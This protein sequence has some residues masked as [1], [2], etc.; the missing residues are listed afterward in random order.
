MIYQIENIIEQALKLDFDDDRKIEVTRRKHVRLAIGLRIEIG[1]WRNLYPAKVIYVTWDLQKLV[2]QNLLRINKKLNMTPE[3]EILK[4]NIYLGINRL[5][6]RLSM[7]GYM[8]SSKY[9]FISNGVPVSELR[10]K[11]NEYEFYLKGIDKWGI[12]KLQHIYNQIENMLEGTRKMKQA[13][14][15][16]EMDL[17]N[18]GGKE[19]NWRER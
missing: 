2:Y 3:K 4:R 16:E 17:M 11:N 12:K 8:E 13:E 9:I 6:L 15:D 18:L 19:V 1:A 14:E 5:G 7:F 10:V